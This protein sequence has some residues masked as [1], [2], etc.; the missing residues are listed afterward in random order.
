[1]EKAYCKKEYLMSVDNKNNVKYFFMKNSIY[2]IYYSDDFYCWVELDYG[3]LQAF[4]LNVNKHPRFDDYFYT[5]K[6][7]RK[8]KISELEK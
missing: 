7:L 6:E 2:N 3:M 1:M 8:L 4:Y 5:L